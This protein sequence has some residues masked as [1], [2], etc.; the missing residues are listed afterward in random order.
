[1]FDFFDIYVY[2]CVVVCIYIYFKNHYDIFIKYA[3]GFIKIF[4]YIYI[5]HINS[6]LPLDLFPLII[7]PSSN[8]MFT[9]YVH[10]L[11]YVSTYNLNNH[12]QNKTYNIDL[13]GTCQLNSLNTNMFS[14]I[15]LLINN[16][17]IFLWSWKTIHFVYRHILFIQ[18]YALGYQI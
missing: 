3:L 7:F 17:F 13:L 4:S 10:V 9:V 15:Q 8:S 2:M 11:L 16:N 6:I 5:M 12:K 18:Y 14:Y 1:M